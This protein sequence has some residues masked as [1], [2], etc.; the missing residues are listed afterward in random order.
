MQVK[1]KVFLPASVGL[2]SDFLL[3]WCAGISPLDSLTPNKGITIYFL[4]V[5]K[6]YVCLGGGGGVTAENA[7]SAILL[8]CPTKN[9][10]F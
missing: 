5:V 6:I 10:L 4:V 3:K 8:T 1:G 9:F 2:I 7:S